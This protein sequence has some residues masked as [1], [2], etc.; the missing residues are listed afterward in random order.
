[1]LTQCRALHLP[2]QVA[3]AVLYLCFFEQGAKVSGLL[4]GL[5]NAQQLE[6]PRANQSV[7]QF[8]RTQVSSAV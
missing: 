8:C 4:P 7:R 2:Q 6:E 1:M 3:I 5:Y